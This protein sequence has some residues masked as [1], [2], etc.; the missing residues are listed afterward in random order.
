VAAA[1][2]CGLNFLPEIH[3]PAALPDVLA[4]AGG[5]LRIVG[6]P[7][8]ASRTVAAALADRRGG[9]EIALLVGPEG[10]FTEQEHGLVAGAGFIPVRLGRTTLRVETAAV[11][12]LAAVIAACDAAVTPTGGPF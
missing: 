4:A 7:A 1:K 2:Q 9:Q 8:D 3:S 6:D 11:A 12:L 10:G 5:A